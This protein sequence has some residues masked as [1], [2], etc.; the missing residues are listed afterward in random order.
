MQKLFDV[1]NPREDEYEALKALWLRCFDDSPSVVERFFKNAVTAENV[2]AA[3]S[4]G[5]PVSVLYIIESTVTNNGKDYKAF[6]I[7]AVCTDPDFRGKGLMKKCFD[8]L[9]ALSKERGVDYLFLVP[10]EES[11]FEMYKKL[12]FKNGFYYS[13]KIV[14]SKDFT[15]ET[16]TF[17]NLSFEDYKFIRKSFSDKLNLA[18]LGEKGFKGFLSP[19]SETVKALKCGNGYVVYEKENDTV[20][21]H[22]LF[23]DENSLLKCVFKLTNMT[24]LTVRGFAD[25]KTVPFGMYLG[26]SDAPPIDNAF[27]GI[28]YGG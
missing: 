22:E 20:T 24:S 27:F 15:G 2:V 28:A 16:E 17:E 11:L 8:F 10:A 3:F 23:G 5:E 12:G 18:T 4:D 1:R 9:F 7:Y 26:V 14:C 19:E 21:V 13:E 25:E 6:Y